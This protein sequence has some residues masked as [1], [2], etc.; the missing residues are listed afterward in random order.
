[1]LHKPLA[2]I[3]RSE[4]GAYPVTLEI[5]DHLHESIAVGCTRSRLAVLQSVLVSAVGDSLKIHQ[6]RQSSRIIERPDPEI[7][8]YAEIDVESTHPLIAFVVMVTFANGEDSTTLPV[9]RVNAHKPYWLPSHLAP[10]SPDYIPPARTR[11]RIHP[12][13]LGLLERDPEA[14]KAFKWVESLREG[15]FPFN[16]D[17]TYEFNR[18]FHVL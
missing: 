13:E 11:R 12:L 2:L 9:F 16:K 7:P 5:W 17:N 14:F 1:M 3:H 4:T 15:G 6:T 10:T 8:A 18:C